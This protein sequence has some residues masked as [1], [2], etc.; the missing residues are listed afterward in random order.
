[1]AAQTDMAAL[2]S[3]MG[4]FFPCCCLFRLLGRL[5]V[6]CAHLQDAQQCGSTSL[7]FSH[8]S[9]TT[10]RMYTVVLQHRTLLIGAHH[11]NLIL[12]NPSNFCYH[13][14]PQ[15]QILEE[16]VNNRYLATPGH[17]LANLFAAGC[18][19]VGLWMVTILNSHL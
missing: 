12:N 8:Y 7:H 2:A 16:L 13:M 4:L 1:M 18:E 6:L 14:F 3:G 19:K 5:H 15:L 11:T 17:K 9:L 10:E